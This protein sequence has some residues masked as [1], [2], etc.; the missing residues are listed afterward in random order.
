MIAALAVLQQENG[1][2]QGGSRVPEMSSSSS[3]VSVT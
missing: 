3:A 2:G 1:D